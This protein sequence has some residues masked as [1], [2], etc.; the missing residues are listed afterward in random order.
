MKKTQNDSAKFVF[1]A[2]LILISGGCLNNQHTGPT[3]GQSMTTSAQNNPTEVVAGVEPCLWQ[4]LKAT[5][6]TCCSLHEDAGF[7]Q[8]VINRD[9]YRPVFT[10]G[11]ETG[12]PRYLS[13]PEARNYL[14]LTVRGISTLQKNPSA[15]P[16]Q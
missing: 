10:I 11:I 13:I 8:C 1:M 14:C 6:N 16:A 2:C 9:H 5:A 15:N 12:Q 3:V 7:I 4:A